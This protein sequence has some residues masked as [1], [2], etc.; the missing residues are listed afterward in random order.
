MKDVAIVSFA[1]TPIGRFGCAFKDLT[2]VDLG[3]IAIEE[4]IKRAGVSTEQIDEVAMGVVWQAGLKANPARQAAI[5]AG[6][7]VEAP[8][9]TIN[10]QCSSGIRAIDIASDQIR[11]GKARVIVA[12]GFESMSGVPFLDVSGRWGHARGRKSLEDGLYYDGLDDAFSGTNMGNTAETVGKNAL[13]TREET[14][15]FALES[16]Q[17]A[18]RAISSGRF[19]REIVPVKIVD[20]KGEEMIISEDE[21]SRPNT[22]IEDLSRLQP[23]FDKVGISTAGNSPP[24]SDGAAAL[25]LM[26]KE[27]AKE[28]NFPILGF[29]KDTVSISVPPEIMG[30]GPVPAVKRLLERNKLA[31]EDI[32]LLEINEAFGAQALACIK[33]LGFPMDIVN[34]NGGA[35]ALGHPPG[36]TGARL[37][38]SLLLELGIKGKRYGIATLCAGGGPAIAMLVSVEE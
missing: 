2:A 17:K 9:I 35:I 12:G 5:R 21:C 24:L 32:G 26:E 14:D 6:V 3:T 38:G 33:E 25:V 13:L 23:V 18:A 1:R 7:N 16:Q 28:N 10:Q 27:Y 29:I 37:V 11:L 36:N 34:V 15:A 30:Y 22:K 8:A 4:A 20:R 31:V 19:N